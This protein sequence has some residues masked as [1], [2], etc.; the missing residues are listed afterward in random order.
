MPSPQSVYDDLVQSGKINADPAQ[1]Q[2]MERLD[3]L[4]EDLV[5]YDS[6][7]GKQGWAAR[8]GIGGKKRQPPKGLYLWGGVGRGC[9]LYTS[10]SPRD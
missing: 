4:G 5:A 6:Q 3:K 10:P 7:M 8:L 1:A 2:A 9:L